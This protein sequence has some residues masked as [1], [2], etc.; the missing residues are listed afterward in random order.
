M[1]RGQKANHEVGLQETQSLV[2][3]APTTV[4]SRDALDIEDYGK[5]SCMPIQYIETIS[6]LSPVVAKQKIY[7]SNR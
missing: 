5:K 6:Q 3:V 4:R 2:N 7:S 1:G